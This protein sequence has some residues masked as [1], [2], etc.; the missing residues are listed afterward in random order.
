VRGNVAVHSVV[1]SLGTLVAEADSDDVVGTAEAEDSVQDVNT[2]R[3][4]DTVKAADSAGVVG[5][6]GAVGTA[7]DV[8]AIDSTSQQTSVP[9]DSRCAE[10]CTFIRPGIFCAPRLDP[11]NSRKWRDL[12][13]TTRL[14]RRKK[15]ELVYCS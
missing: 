4:V 5:V 12:T 1:G 3:V 15:G 2:V 7:E 6:A 13:S 8:A 11:P 9:L 10:N 14:T